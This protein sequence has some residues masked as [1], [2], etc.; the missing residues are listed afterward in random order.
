[1][2]VFHITCHNRGYKK[3]CLSKKR[4]FSNSYDVV[5]VVYADRDDWVTIVHRS[6]EESLHIYQLF[7]FN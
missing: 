5:T 2:S 1:M 7:S 4:T 6:V 3:H